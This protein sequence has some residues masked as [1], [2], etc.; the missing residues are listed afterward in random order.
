MRT[1]LTKRASPSEAFASAL[2]GHTRVLHGD[3][4]NSVVPH[5]Q[6]VAMLRRTWILPT[7]IQSTRPSSW[8]SPASRHRLTNRCHR[9]L[10]A[11]LTL[12]QPTIGR[13]PCQPFWVA[14]AR[15]S[16][17]TASNQKVALLGSCCFQGSDRVPDVA[18]FRPFR[19]GEAGIPGGATCRYS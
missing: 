17:R 5:T 10:V 4:C 9:V 13:C 11:T 15:V 1:A 8:A 3:R 2:P 14:E 6:T 12:Q 19:P 7:G 16:A 18:R